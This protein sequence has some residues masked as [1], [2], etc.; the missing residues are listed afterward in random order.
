MKRDARRLSALA[1]ALLCAC[2][3]L[4]AEERT[5]RFVNL[6]VR[7]GLANASVSSLVQDAAG[8]IWIGTQ[9]GLHR[10]DGNSFAIY[11]NEPFDD[12]SLPHNLI[13]T[14]YMDEDG[15]TLWLGTYGGLTR[16][17]TRSGR[18]Q[19]WAHDPADPRS[20]VND[21]VVAIARDAEGRLWVGTLEGLDRME[22]G[23]FVHYKAE[24]DKPDALG[25]PVIRSIFR[26]SKGRLWIGSSGGG[27]HLYVPES[28]SFLRYGT[29]GVRRPLLPSDY[30]FDI[31]EDASGSLWLGLWYYGLARFDP[32]AGTLEGYPL[33]DNRV[34]FINAAEEG[35]VRAGTWGGGLFELNTST[36]LVRRFGRGVDKAW[37]L[38]HDTMYSMLVDKSGEVWIGSNGGG[39]SHMLRDPASFSIFEH[40]E[41]DPA[42]IGSGKVI[43]LLEDSKGRLWVGS[44]NGGLARLDPGAKGFVHYRYDK[45]DGRSLPN[46]IV[47]RVYEDSR[48]DIWALTNAGMARYDES[49]DDFDRY[50]RK[51]DDPDSLADDVLY[52]IIEEPGSGNFW[53]GSYTHGLEYWDRAANRF[54]HFPARKG[55]E[56]AL[57][58]NL[59][60]DLAYDSLGRLWVGTNGGLYRHEGGGRFKA[61][62][63]DKNDR[64]SL[65]S[66][67][68]RGL[69]SAADG[70]LWIATNGGGVAKYL[71]DTDSFRYWTKRDG[72]PSNVVLA[73]QEGSDGQIWASTVTGLS[74]FEPASSRWRPFGGPSDLR[75]NEF[76]VGNA[77]GKNGRLYFGAVNA[78]YR[79]DSRLVLRR[80]F[81]PPVRLTSIMVD[82]QE[83]SPDTSP[84]LLDELSLPWDTGSVAFTF[85]A[86]DYRDPS[87]NQ[88]AYMLE[89]LDEGW[90]FSGS[91]DYAGYT[92][93]TPGRSYVFRVKASNNEGVWN[94]EGLALRVR[95]QTSPWLSWWAI[96][97]YALVL[98]SFVW[99]LMTLRS[100]ARLRGEVYELSRLKSELE[101]ANVKLEELAS[102][103]GLTG[104]LNRR[105]FNIELERRF[106]AAQA[107]GEPLSVL[108]VDI[109]CFKPYNDH[110][111]HQLGD[112]AL[113]A[114]ANGIR[115]ALERPQD[116]VARYGGEE[117][118]VI[119]PGT[120]LPGALKVAERI[121]YGIAELKLPHESSTVLP[122]VTVSVGAAELWPQAGMKPAELLTLAD[123]AL[124]RAKDAGRNRVAS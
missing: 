94:E 85:A 47:T 29:E 53:I 84:W 117:F 78:V 44:Y 2:A 66:R 24:P 118:A 105:S 64:G 123:S 23:G 33:A 68:I 56:G 88:F 59:V 112:E 91:R 3:G 45:V 28:D 93:L 102:H 101:E 18:I 98:G 48:G 69:R 79:I 55:E 6:G 49:R 92:N 25:A 81:L 51:A 116:S 43:S 7:E 58:D 62:L 39:L 15:Y 26:D 36:G 115:S 38:A 60:Y 42:S 106:K 1:A 61:Y 122:L 114:V 21:V 34:Y 86:L 40:E 52:A 90:T 10:W 46:D 11:E 107:L 80:D 73:I 77:V 95:V 12:Q 8:F 16:F 99:L 87:R 50:A 124:Y 89:G 41:A 30:V 54:I 74:F 111:G 100:K 63:P 5:V 32:D 67:I 121:R 71:P 27:L 76:T 104:L 4:E 17:D 82:N 70:S 22:D 113:M 96:L 110:Y 120:E 75:Y 20:L 119:L 14:M 83:A 35:Y 109:D 13:Q 72:L 108:M 103:D 9:G 37:S 65:P 57:G 19:T 97:L 31:R